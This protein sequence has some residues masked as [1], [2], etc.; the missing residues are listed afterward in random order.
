MFN[1]SGICQ[2][3]LHMSSDATRPGTIVIFNNVGHLNPLVNTYLLGE[4]DGRMFRHM[5]ARLK[6]EKC[7]RSCCE[8]MVDEERLI[9]LPHHGCQV[10][11]SAGS[12]RT[13]LQPP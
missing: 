2:D 4:T 11:L 6:S 10:K 9:S 7:N 5:G 1:D 3:W 12:L 13:C 8:K